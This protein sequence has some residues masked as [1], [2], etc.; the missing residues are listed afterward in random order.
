MMSE[1][2]SSFVNMSPFICIIKDREITNCVTKETVN[3]Y[4]REALV[5]KYRYNRLECHVKAEAGKRSHSCRC[6]LGIEES[7]NV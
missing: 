6:R 1:S 4:I 2:P 3:V 7:V 5:T